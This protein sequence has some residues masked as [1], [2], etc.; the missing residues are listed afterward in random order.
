[1]NASIHY[2]ASHNYV[3]CTRNSSCLIN[4]RCECTIRLLKTTHVL[5]AV[6]DVGGVHPWRPQFI[7]LFIFMLLSAKLYQT[8]KHSSR[9]RTNSGGVA[10]PRGRPKGSALP[11][12]QTPPPGCRMTNAFENITFP[13]TSFADHNNRKAPPTL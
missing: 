1:M 10:P 8:R 13:Q 5:D 2:N 4:R 7:F 11:Q 6:A 3:N 9:M 12:M